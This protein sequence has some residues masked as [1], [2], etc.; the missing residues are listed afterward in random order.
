MTQ[1]ASRDDKPSKRQ[2]KVRLDPEAF[3]LL[4][5]LC[6]KAR[7]LPAGQIEFMTLMFQKY[8]LEK[9]ALSEAEGFPRKRRKKG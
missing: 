1:P 8:G 7:R 5:E 6:E 3:D 2:L 9:L 4:L